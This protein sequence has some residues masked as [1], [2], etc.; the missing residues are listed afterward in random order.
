MVHH[1]HA[2]NRCREKILAHISRAALLIARAAQAFYVSR[3][4]F[5]VAGGVMLL[6]LVDQIHE[7][8]RVDLADLGSASAHGSA[9]LHLTFDYVFLFF[10]SWSIMF[11]S[12]YALVNRFAPESLS[13][14]G[15]TGYSWCLDSRTSDAPHIDATTDHWL[16]RTVRR[17]LPLL[18]GLL[19]WISAFIVLRLAAVGLPDEARVR[20]LA[21]S[22]VAI[23]VGVGCI[24]SFYFSYAPRILRLPGGKRSLDATA[25][26][27]DHEAVLLPSMLLALGSLGWVALDPLSFG[28]WLGTIAVLLSAC[29][30][31]LPILSWLSASPLVPRWHVLSLLLAMAGLWSLLNLNDNHEVRQL[32]S[33]KT[34]LKARSFNLEFREWL[35]SRKRDHPSDPVPVVLVAAEGGG[36]RAAYFTAQVLAQLADRCR[37]F[38]DHLLAISGVS[39]GAVGATVFAGLLDARR[40]T[41][42]TVPLADQVDRVLR[43][44]L[45]APLVAS[46][47]FA[48]GIQRFLP[49]PVPSLDR[50]RTLEASIEQAFRN[51]AGTDFMSRSIYRNWNGRSKLPLLLLNATSVDSGERIVVS[52]V[53]LAD[54]KF[55]RLRSFADVAPSVDIRQSTAA[56][57]SARFPVLTP[58]AT[59]PGIQHNR[60]VDGGYFENSGTATLSE[61]LAVVGSIAADAGVEIRPIVVRI[62]N[63]PSRAAA[64]SRGEVIAPSRQ[65]PPAYFIELLSPLRALLN[66]RA[67]R[68]TLASESLRTQVA[69]LREAGIDAAL[70]E[71]QIGLSEVQLPLGWQL[72]NSARQELREQLSSAADCVGAKGIVNSCSVAEVE[73]ALKVGRPRDHGASACE[74]CSIIPI[75]NRPC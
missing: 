15:A 5:L 21:L 71:F 64:P 4:S 39:G 41:P 33:E 73:R 10:L 27:F 35:L 65:P 24:A 13:A 60:L 48:D 7:V 9:L 54:S 43:H 72:S 19:P 1:E 28:Q 47:L 2:L 56:V 63:T 8:V 53:S 62:G 67:A 31:V 68:G 42:V 14:T 59:L 16:L 29:L 46:M 23:V 61:V 12:N 75:V 49:W 26:Y 17:G 34:L 44:D 69:A 18:L 55:N 3:V 11:W 38:T 36:I 66:A 30:G 25:L 52:P 32:S 50:A 57:L 6:C 20:A 70:I 51:V 45:L 58:A 74:K 40:P 22:I 37:A